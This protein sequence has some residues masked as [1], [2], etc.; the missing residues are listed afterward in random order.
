VAQRSATQRAIHREGKITI[1]ST[2]N[3]ISG[4]SA[5][6]E[7]LLSEGVT[8]LFG[9]PRTTELPIVHALAD[10][11][12]GIVAAQRWKENHRT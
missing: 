7:L 12:D 2:P 8:D 9:N 10:Y 4:R 1:P 5:F 3:T 11:P 6:I